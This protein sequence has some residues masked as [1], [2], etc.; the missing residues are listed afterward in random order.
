MALYDIHNCAIQHFAT[1]I[2]KVLTI[3][4]LNENK[5]TTFE[6]HLNSAIYKGQKVVISDFHL[7]LHPLSDV[8][9]PHFPS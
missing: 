2:F 3:Y 6:L 9:L 4:Q 7:E 5:H 1:C 8:S